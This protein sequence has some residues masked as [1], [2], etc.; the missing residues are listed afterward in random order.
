MPENAVNEVAP[1]GVKQ[2]LVGAQM[3]FVAF[4]ALVLVPLLT[5]LDPNVALFTAGAGTLIFQVVTKRKVPV[6]LA[7]SFAFIAPIIYGVQTWGIPAT[8]CG[9]V[10]AGGLY[11][12]LSLLIRWRGSGILIRILP[13]V[14]TGPVIMVIG[15]ILAPVAVHLAMGRTGDGAAVLVPEPT[16]LVIS[17]I[18]LLTVILVSLL[19]KGMLRLIPILCGIIVGYIVSIPFGLISLSP[20]AKAPWIA[21]PNFV[22]PEWNFQAVLFIVPVAIAPAIEHFGDVLAIGSITGKNYLED[23][24]IQNTMLG[25]GLA[26]SFASFL[27]G[28]PNTTY[29]EVTGAVALIKVFNPV[30][31]TWAAIF[32]IFLAFVGKVGAILQTIPTPVMGGIMLLLFGAMSD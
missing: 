18:S 12:V 10:A 13:P 1:S 29:S 2:V 19:G 3:L 25:D 14:V 4:G 5:G 28:P 23:P 7:S 9:L 21:L 32:A 24:G 27:G 31:M 11:I 8:M 6:F 22:L 26:T 15:L 30:I 20:V 17:M 16:A